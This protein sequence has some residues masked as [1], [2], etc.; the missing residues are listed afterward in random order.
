MLSQSAKS[1]K[2]IHLIILLVSA[3]LLTF[4]AV[5]FFAGGDYVPEL[6]IQARQNSLIVAGDITSLTGQ[7][8]ANLEKISKAFKL[9]SQKN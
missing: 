4:L 6:F 2:N 3:S 5:Y 9:N 8:L 1:E 7:S